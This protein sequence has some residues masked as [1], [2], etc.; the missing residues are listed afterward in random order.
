MLRDRRRP[1]YIDLETNLND[2]I[3]ELQGEVEAFQ[4]M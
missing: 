1:E 2:E 4:K 3:E